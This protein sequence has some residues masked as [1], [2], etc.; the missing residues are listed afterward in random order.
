MISLKDSPGREMRVS[1]A[2]THV[3]TDVLG[4][5]PVLPSSGR[6]DPPANSQSK[7]LEDAL[8]G[9]LAAGG[10]IS[11]DWPLE[12]ALRVGDEATGTRVLETL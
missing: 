9:I 5:S 2:H 10:N 11:E 7:G 8:R 4:R 6:A 3:G 12:R 1:I